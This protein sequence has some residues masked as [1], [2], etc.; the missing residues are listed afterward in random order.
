M[1]EIL[2]TYLQFGAH[3]L[4][5]VSLRNFFHFICFLVSQKIV[6]SNT[7]GYVAFPCTAPRIIK[8]DFR[9]YFS[10]ESTKVLN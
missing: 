5:R 6:D 8:N 1:Y 2:F 4:K 7:K 10:S 3:R 9:S